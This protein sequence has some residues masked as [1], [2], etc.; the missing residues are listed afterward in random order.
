MG[1][2]QFWSNDH[3]G[4]V[5]ALSTLCAIGGRKKPVRAAGLMTTHRLA[6]VMSFAIQCDVLGGDHIP[7]PLP[8]KCHDI[9]IP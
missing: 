3:V 4:Y 1:R 6:W 7:I 8:E 9:L 5:V 2:K